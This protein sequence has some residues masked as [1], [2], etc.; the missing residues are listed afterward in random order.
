M[1]PLGGDHYY[2]RQNWILFSSTE[3]DLLKGFLL[4]VCRHLCMVQSEKE[5]EQLAIQYKLT[6]VQSLRE[7]ISAI[8]LPSSRT[9][10]GKALVL[11]MDE[12]SS[13]LSIQELYTGRTM[14]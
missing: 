10:V 4:A 9:A 12:V 1:K 3:V 7:A 2:R 8:G 6:Y 14:H 13:P 11:S 5:C